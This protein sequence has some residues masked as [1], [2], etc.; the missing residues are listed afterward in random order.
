M[1]RPPY[2]EYVANISDGSCF[3]AQLYDIVVIR[4]CRPILNREL[5][6]KQHAPVRTDSFFFNIL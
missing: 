2:D 5:K 3:A 6:D 4:K 1:Y